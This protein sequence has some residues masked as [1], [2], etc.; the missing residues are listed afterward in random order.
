MKKI[1]ALFFGLAFAAF[2]DVVV[3]D[4]PDPQLITNGGFET[5]T[6]SGW[7]V[8]TNDTPGNGNWF[9]TSA[10]V[11]PLTGNP[12]VGPASGTY[13][14][15]TDAY[16]PGSRA[17]TQSFT[18]PVGA[19]NVVLSGDIFVNDWN[20]GSGLGGEVDVLANGANPLTGAPIVIAYGPADT[21]VSGGTPNGYVA[22]SDNITALTPGTYQLRVLEMDSTGLINV[23]ADNL[24]ITYTP[25][26]VPEPSSVV[27]LSLLCGFLIYRVRKVFA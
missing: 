6:F 17:L 20:G 25:A 13:Y 19:T 26:V 4:S 23:G 7:T 18:L 16:E 9:V 22:F 8:T 14:A 1:S 15:V 11:T 21:S 27:P 10:T 24:S 12:T 3:S 5:G 2:G